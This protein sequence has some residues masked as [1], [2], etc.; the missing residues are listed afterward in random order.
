MA[1]PTRPLLSLLKLYLINVLAILNISTAAGAFVIIEVSGRVYH[2]W[3]LLT[4]GTEVRA[5]GRVPPL[6]SAQHTHVWLMTTS[7]QI[8]TCRSRIGS[9]PWAHSTTLPTRTH[10]RT[11]LCF[12]IYSGNAMRLSKDFGALIQG[13]HF[14]WDL[15]LD[16]YNSVRDITWAG[17]LG[18]LSYAQRERGSTHK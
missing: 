2:R 3:E 15:H 13:E 10:Q 9:L 6:P 1:F 17:Q 12:P 7:V 8:F 18:T 4:G 5:A 16:I 14:V 11:L